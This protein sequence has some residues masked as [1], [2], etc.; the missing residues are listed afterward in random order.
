MKNAVVM[1]AAFLSVSA[2]AADNPVARCFETITTN[3]RLAPLAVKVGNG[4]DASV[5]T[6]EQLAN[7]AFASDEEKL[8]VAEWYKARRLCVNYG[9]NYYSVN[10][11]EH[12]AIY[13]WQQAE[14]SLLMASLFQGKVTYGEFVT[15]RQSLVAEGK[16]R[17]SQEQQ[18]VEARSRQ[19]AA[20]A[21][22]GN[23]LKTA[24]PDS[25]HP[26]QPS[27]K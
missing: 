10:F 21:V 4:T 8:L 19:A 2:W 5:F 25:A 9:A 1:G 23:A 15:K 14:F 17:A 3:P 13:E 6:P 26:V 27:S 11:P 7:P 24:S 22:F 16:L 12:L 18:I 20:N